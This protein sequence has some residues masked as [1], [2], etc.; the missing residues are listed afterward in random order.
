[1]Y[2]RCMTH[3]SLFS[4]I[5]GFDLAAEWMG[6]ENKFHCEI[7]EFC[8]KILNYYWPNAKSHKD[9]TKTDFSIYRGCIDILTGGD[10]CQGNSVIGLGGGEYSNYFMWPHFI[11]AA[12]EI[13]PATL[14]NEN[15][16][17]QIS[18][19]VIERKITDLKSIG[20]EVWPP[21][22][23]PASFT[24]NY[25]QRERV[26]II[27]NTTEGR[28]EGRHNSNKKRQWEYQ[29]G[30]I[31]SLVEDQN[32]LLSPKQDIHWNTYGVPRQ[33]DRITVSEHRKE[34]LMA[35]GN[36]IVPQVAYEIFKTIET[37]QNG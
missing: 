16:R 4:G 10:P 24:G 1:M 12:K 27:A 33:L 11:R 18:N 14:V 28:L 22:I 26:F 29:G 13:R 30:S 8:N 25:T 31:S 15:V 17:G 5:G 3:G 34:S 32:G 6:W 23:I 9:I 37:F 36:A 20:Y 19:R 7:N 2:I 21:I 35:Y